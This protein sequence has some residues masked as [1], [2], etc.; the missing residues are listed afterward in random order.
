MAVYRVEIDVATARPPGPHETLYV[1]VDAVSDHDAV[2]AACQ[3]AA[4]RP[5]VVM[6]V[7]ARLTDWPS[8]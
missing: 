8:E 1:D 4:C 6:P 7:A 3:L 2:L 5:G